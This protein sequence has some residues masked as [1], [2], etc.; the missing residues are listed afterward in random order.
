MR[1]VPAPLEII[2]YVAL[3]ITGGILI[4]VGTTDQLVGFLICGAFCIPLGLITLVYAIR[5]TLWHRDM[6]RRSVTDEEYHLN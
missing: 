6:K 1:R 2:G 5:N 4:Y 3:P